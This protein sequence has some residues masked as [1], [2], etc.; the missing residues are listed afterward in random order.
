VGPD[1][2]LKDIKTGDSVRA[3]FVEATAVLV[4]RDSAPI[5]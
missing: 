5:K 2:S 3:E 1:V 4:T